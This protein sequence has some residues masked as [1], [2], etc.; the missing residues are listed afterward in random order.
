LS[1]FKFLFKFFQFF[2]RGQTFSDF[3]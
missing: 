1:S 3:K 2:Q